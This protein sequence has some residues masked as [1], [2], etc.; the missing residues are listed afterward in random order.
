VSARELW[1]KCNANRD[2]HISI[3]E[4]STC[5]DE[6]VFAPIMKKARHDADRVK[7]SLLSVNFVSLLDTNNDNTASKDELFNFM[8]ALPETKQEAQA[9]VRSNNQAEK[10]EKLL[11]KHA[12]DAATRVTNQAARQAAREANQA[13]RKAAQEA[14]RAAR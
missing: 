13:A 4:V 9:E 3:E 10:A 5:V 7:K 11:N 1:A 14:K 6:M 12:E 2:D 8:N